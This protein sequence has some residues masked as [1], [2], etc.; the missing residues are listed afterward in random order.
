M[1]R[2]Q[3]PHLRPHHAHDHTSR[4][5]PHS[6]L[7]SPPTTPVCPAGRALQLVRR[8]QTAGMSHRSPSQRT[9]PL[10]AP[11]RCPQLRTGR[12]S[13]PLGSG[14]EASH[15]FS[16]VPLS[17]SCTLCPLCIPEHS[18]KLCAHG[19]TELLAWT[20]Y[21]TNHICTESRV[22]SRGAGRKEVSLMGL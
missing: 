1:E 10:R 5:G 2:R 8:P 11:R 22:A 12:A 4:P 7:L 14:E 15:L 16:G 18:G 3:L 9:L 17:A 21:L 13:G 20:I 19:A 6:T